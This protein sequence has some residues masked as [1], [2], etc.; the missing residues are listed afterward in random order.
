MF[1][2][3][4]LHSNNYGL[5]PFPYFLK[6][7]FGKS[8]QTYI[9]WKTQHIFYQLYNTLCSIYKDKK[10]LRLGCSLTLR[11]TAELKRRTSSYLIGRSH[12]ALVF[13]MALTLSPSHNASN[14]GSYSGT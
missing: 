7:A 2:A 13:F 8:S 6:V 1:R 14:C 11:S 3:N 12:T 5:K 9:Q 4:R 10:T